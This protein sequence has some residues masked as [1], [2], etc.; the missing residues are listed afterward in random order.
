MQRLPAVI[1]T[2]GV[3]MVATLSATAGELTFNAARSAGELGV[4]QDWRVQVKG[5]ALTI[6]RF[7]RRARTR[8]LSTDEVD[9][10]GRAILTPAFAA[11][12][13]TYGCRTCT[14]ISF[15]SIEV[16]AGPATQHVAV[17]EYVQAPPGADTR[18][19]RE[20]GQFYRAWQL[21]KE[22]AGL[23]GIPDHCRQ[24]R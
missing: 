10:L 1:L 19:G 14:D 17:F 7:G 2:A 18:E 8:Q 20:L 24:R 12:R 6:E 21:I 4:G 15:C 11:L 5:S 3:L 22:L 13:E 23:D 16:T 9:A